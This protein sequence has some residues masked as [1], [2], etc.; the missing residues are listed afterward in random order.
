[1]SEGEIGALLGAAKAGRHGVRDHLLLLLMF[2]HGLRL[3]EAV[4]QRRDE[5][6]IDRA[7]LWRSASSQWGGRDCAV[8]R[9]MICTSLG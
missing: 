1:L 5:L 7:R 2:R 8:V 9:L 4:G 6:D 3:S